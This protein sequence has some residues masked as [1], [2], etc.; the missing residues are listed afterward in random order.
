MCECANT[1]CLE[2]IRMTTRE[3]AILRE[4][5]TYFA[6]AQSDQHVVP[7]CERIVGKTDRYWIV[8]KLGAAAKIVA[9][10]RATS[11]IAHGQAS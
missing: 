1:D 7:E 11:E 9:E 5:P 8:E 10:D 2:Q 3:Y 4:T 6:V